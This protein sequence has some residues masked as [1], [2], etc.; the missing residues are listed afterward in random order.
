MLTF[1]GTFADAACRNQHADVRQVWL[2]RQDDRLFAVAILS[3]LVAGRTSRFVEPLVLGEGE[4]DGEAWSYAWQRNGQDW[5]ASIAPGDGAVKLALQRN[6]QDPVSIKLTGQA[7]VDDEVITLAPLTSI[8]DWR[9]WFDVV[10][11]GHF[12][13]A[14]VPDC[15]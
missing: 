3:T 14:E 12:S 5:Q 4:R 2:W 1:L 11:T 13:T 15:K 9:H 7:I 6:D 10:L 8:A